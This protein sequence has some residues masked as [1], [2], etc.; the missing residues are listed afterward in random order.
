MSETLVNPLPKLHALAANSPVEGA[1]QIEIEEG[2]PVFR[3]SSFIQTR[4][5]DLLAK[6]QEVELTQ[7]EREELDLYEEIDDY[8][9]FV[10]RVVRNFPHV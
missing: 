3:A 4:I 7:K 10:N 5:E 9:S 2:V 6:N 1:V 8:L